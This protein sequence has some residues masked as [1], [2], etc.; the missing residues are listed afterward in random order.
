[1]AR[2][3]IFIA[4]LL[5]IAALKVGEAIIIPIVTAALF[6]LVLAPLANRIQQ[7]VK[8]AAIAALLSSLCCCIGAVSLLYVVIYHSSS[9]AAQVEDFGPRFEQKLAVFE[10]DF[11][12][13]LRQFTRHLPLYRRAENEAPPEGVMAII[14][15]AEN[16]SGPGPIAFMMTSMFKMIVAPIG[17]GA[18]Q[19]LLILL[20]S[21]VFLVFRYSVRD[22]FLALVAIERREE[23]LGYIH[24][25]SARLGR[26]LLAFTFTNALFG[27][28]LGITFYLLDTPSPWFFALIFALLRF[29]PFI[30]VP[31]G[32][33]GMLLVLFVV[34][35]GWE[36]Y[37]FPVTTLFVID[38]ILTNVFEPLLYSRSCDVHPVVVVLSAMFW[39]WL[40]GPIGFILSIP[41]TMT[42]LMFGSYFPAVAPYCALATNEKPGSVWRRA[43][44]P[45]IILPGEYR[46]KEVVAAPATSQESVARVVLSSEVSP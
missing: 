33:I 18:F 11:R 10:R 15:A 3:V 43:G 19:F 26:F 41:L 40:W 39:A 37:V 30:G 29:V 14:D 36:D 38:L 4:V 32:G 1:M 44:A 28:L 23:T 17:S 16:R 27:I 13:T 21:T 6:A 8:N 5:G 12:G 42:L 45:E 7:Y 20:L 22:R 25:G 34:G 35:A 46:E 31:L 2:A 24:E 9:F